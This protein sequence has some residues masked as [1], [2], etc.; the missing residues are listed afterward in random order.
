VH[1]LK[2]ILKLNYFQNTLFAHVTKYRT[3][4][5]FRK[6][7]KSRDLII[8]WCSISKEKLYTRLGWKECKTI[9]LIIIESHQNEILLGNVHKLFKA[10]IH[11]V[12]TC[13]IFC[14]HKTIKYLANNWCR[15]R[16]FL[17]K[18]CLLQ[19]F[20]ILNVI[21][22]HFYVAVIASKEPFCCSGGKEFKY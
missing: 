4:V 2:R 6:R 9:H 3:T 20:F 18:S 22:S 21:Q 19:W 12:W 16:K 10:F 5:S 8:Y 11:R 14:M 15:G 17:T 1:E 13:I 7:I